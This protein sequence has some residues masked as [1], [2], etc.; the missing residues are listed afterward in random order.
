MKLKI[1][2]GM[3]FTMTFIACKTHKQFVD[4]T[5]VEN[6]FISGK[7]YL[8]KV[9]SST[10]FISPYVIEVLNPTFD[11]LDWL[12]D[13][14]ILVESRIN[15]T[16]FSIIVFDAYTYFD[17]MNYEDIVEYPKGRNDKIIC[18]KEQPSRYKKYSVKELQ[19]SNYIID[20]IVIKE[21]KRLVRY[22]VNQKP[23]ILKE[24]QLFFQNRN[25]LIFELIGN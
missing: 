15:D 3:W 11:T 13:E 24:S 1:I 23:D 9:D 12:I 20:K 16:T 18:V 25:W 6:N 5:I 22:F 19:K 14:T 17:I 2:I 8:P 4:F 10:S 7:C 21:Q